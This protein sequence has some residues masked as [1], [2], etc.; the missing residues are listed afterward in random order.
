MVS[1]FLFGDLAFFDSLSCCLPTFFDA[2]SLTKSERGRGS[3]RERGRER[4][5]ERK[6]ERDRE[7]ERERERERE[8][9]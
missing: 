5:R 3:E 4:E 8:R 6:S 1:F 9:E 2:L 7:K